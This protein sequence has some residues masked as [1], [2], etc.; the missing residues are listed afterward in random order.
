[1][2]Q[3]LINDTYE[4]WSTDNEIDVT[5]GIEILMKEIKEEN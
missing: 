2:P 4:P 3:D 1:M 5:Y